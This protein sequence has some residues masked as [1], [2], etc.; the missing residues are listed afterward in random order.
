MCNLAGYARIVIKDF[1]HKGLKRFFTTGS[2]SGIQAIHAERLRLLLAMLDQAT[3]VSDMD[4]PT[5]RLHALKG[6]LKGHWSVTVQANWRM[7]FRFKDGDAY[8]VDY[9]DYH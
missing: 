1:A 4:A 8:V 5:L 3:Q 2:T 6:D 9:Q 7:T